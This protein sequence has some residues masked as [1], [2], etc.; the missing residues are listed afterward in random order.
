[1]IENVN[2]KTSS[3][4]RRKEK[5]EIRSKQIYYINEKRTHKMMETFSCDV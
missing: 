3:K 5:N 4:K 2:E 1:M